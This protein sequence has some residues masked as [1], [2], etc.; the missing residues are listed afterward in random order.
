MVLGSFGSEYIGEIGI[1]VEKRKK[2]ELLRVLQKGGG[3]KIEVPAQLFDLI[4]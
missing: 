3:A 1:F 4:N 2:M